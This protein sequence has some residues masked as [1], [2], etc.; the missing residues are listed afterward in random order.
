MR[1]NQASFVRGE[2]HPQRLSD[3]NARSGFFVLRKV[4]DT[5]EKLV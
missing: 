5:Q 2:H 1:A 3:G 4:Y